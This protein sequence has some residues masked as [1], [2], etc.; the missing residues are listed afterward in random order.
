[1]QGI[2][3]GIDVGGSATR[4]TFSRNGLVTNGETIG[5]SGHL[6][7]ASVLKKAEKALHEIAKAVG[8][9]EYVVAGVSGLT[10]HTVEAK[11]LELLIKHFLGASKVHLMSDIELATRAAFPRN[12]G[13]LV[14]AGTGSIAAYLGKAEILQ[15]AGGK[16][17]LIDDAGGGYWIAVTALR[18]ILRAED[19]RPGSG[20][21][22]QLGQA[23]SARLGGTEW[24]IVRSHF[25]QLDRGGVAL[26]AIAVGEA[27]HAGDPIARDVLKSAGLE[28]GLLAEQLM[29]RTGCKKIALS[30]RASQ[31]HDNILEAMQTSLKTI[32]VQVMQLN[33]AKTALNIAQKLHDI[34]R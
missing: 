34:V 10:A 14:Y 12:D 2:S 15:T 6:S 31:L 26:L 3:L 20:W 29:I 30:G 28:L 27:T 24:P 1:M 13:I 9:V 17:V 25:Y 8:S 11:Q 22:T 5:F 7:D 18:R 16:G 33:L 19:R 23:L 4:W 32:P 21:S